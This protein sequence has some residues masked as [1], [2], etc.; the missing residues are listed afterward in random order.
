VIDLTA[1]GGIASNTLIVATIQTYRLGV[2]VASVRLNYPSAG[3][4]TIYLTKV[5]SSASA[6]SVAWIAAES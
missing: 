5:P 1:K 2:S 3:K 4:A 6:T